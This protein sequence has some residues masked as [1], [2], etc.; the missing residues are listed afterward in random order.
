MLLAGRV[1]LITGGAYSAAKAAM[2]GS[3]K[4]CAREL[5][6]HGIR[7]NAI[8]PGFIDTGIIGAAMTPEPRARIESSIPMG[9]GGRAEEV[10]GCCLF[11]ACDLSSYCTG[12]E[13]EPN[14]GMLIH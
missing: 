5:A 9:R 2:L 13:I 7:V 3:T 11:L 8:C 14:G 12:T 4:A 10:A 6:P 1:A